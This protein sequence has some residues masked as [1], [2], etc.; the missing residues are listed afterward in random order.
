MNADIHAA[1]ENAV[2][3]VPEE[4]R[5]EFS[6]A[7]DAWKKTWFE[8]GA[9]ISSDPHM[10]ACGK[11]FDALISLGPSILPLVIEA[12]SV[13]DNVI[14][15]QLYDATQ[16]EANLVIQYDSDDDRI[17]EGEQG[18]ARRVVQ[19]WLASRLPVGKRGC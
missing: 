9:A 10:R 13:P 17:L 7:F 4:K 2:A 15:L 16:P 11:E 12:L 18:R 5:G 19:H 1:I 6:N 3:N 8:G 14:A